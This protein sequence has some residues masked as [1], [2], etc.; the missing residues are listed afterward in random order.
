MTAFPYTL[1]VN[2]LPRLGLIVLRVDETIEQDFR[3][4]F[5]PDIARMYVTRVPSGAEL[6]PDSIAEMERT[7]PAAASLL[8]CE[9]PLDVVGYACTSG[10]TL[11]GADKVRELVMG[12]AQTRAV[13]NPLTAALNQC[14]SLGLER[15]GIVSPYIA[16]IAEPIRAAFE[17]AGILVPDT[18]SFG[19]EVEAK[20]ARIAPSSIAAAARVLANRSK[21]DAVFLSCTNLRT[22]DV[23]APLAEELGL[24]VLSSN[25]CLAAHMAALAK[26]G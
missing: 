3:R 18:L 21:L 6:T 8:P 5:S 22:L 15:V 16:S 2:D 12:V 23:L 14:H 4:L 7:L 26:R 10:T 24:P 9:H 17:A 11:I 1:E 19:E 13:T 20:V 25:Q